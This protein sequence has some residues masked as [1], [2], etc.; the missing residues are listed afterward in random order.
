MPLLVTGV[1][2]IAIPRSNVFE[3]EVAGLTGIRMWNMCP[4]V[5]DHCGPKSYPHPEK[6]HFPL[7]LKEKSKGEVYV[8]F[9]HR[10]ILRKEIW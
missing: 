3:C 6:V 1:S 8:I 9:K 10:D 5:D 4:Y 2:I 7:I